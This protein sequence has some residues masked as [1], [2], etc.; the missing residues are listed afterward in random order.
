MTDVGGQQGWSPN[1]TYPGT[2]V[3]A[4]SGDSIRFSFTSPDD[5]Y[6]FENK[7]HSSM[8]LV[9]GFHLTALRIAMMDVYS[10]LVTHLLLVCWL[11]QLTIT[12][13]QCLS[14]HLVN[15]GYTIL[16]QDQTARLTLQ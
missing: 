1:V 12:L 5:V 2:L 14:T 8:L 6:L 11:Q 16:G 9:N 15:R 7:V 4:L 3:K 13:V 10:M